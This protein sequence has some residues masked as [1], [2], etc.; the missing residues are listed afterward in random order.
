[1]SSPDEV[2]AMIEGAGGKVTDGALLPDGSGFMTAS[3][4]LPKTH[5]IYEAAA[6]GFTGA[7]P[8]PFRMGASD[9]RRQKFSEMVR[10]AAKYAIKASTMRGKDM[11]FD[12]DAMV[13]NFV[14]GMLGYHTED[15]L[16]EAWENPYPVPEPYPGVEQ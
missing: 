1:M 14:V 16:G 15:G 11:D 6:D 9:P 12:P 8:M 7:P 3:F 5:W 13:Q 10:A 4:P 2:R